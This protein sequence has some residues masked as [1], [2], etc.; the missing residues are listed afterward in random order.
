[1][2]QPELRNLYHEFCHLNALAFAGWEFEA[3]YHAL[4][5]AMH[6]SDR[7]RDGDLLAEVQQLA[8]EQGQ[9]IDTHAPDHRLASQNGTKVGHRN[10]FSVAARQAAAMLLTLE[11]QQQAETVK[12]AQQGAG[13]AG[14]L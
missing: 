13:A 2:R 10:I 11:V 8:Q 14:T 12:R 6:C 9:W 4:A 5:A 1:M 7:L 3:A